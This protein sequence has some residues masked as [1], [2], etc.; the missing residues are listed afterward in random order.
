MSLNFP[1]SPTIGQQ[2]SAAGQT[3]VWNGTVWSAYRGG[4]VVQTGASAPTTVAEGLVWFNTN[5]GRT[6]VYYD[7]TWVDTATSAAI[8]TSVVDNSSGDA[9]TVIQQGAGRALAVEGTVAVTGSLNATTITQA[10]SAVSLASELTSH[11]SDTTNIHGIADTSLLATKA[12]ADSAASAA[13]AGVVDSAPETLNTLN[14]LAAALGDDANFATSVTTAIAAKVS[15]SG[16]SIS[17][18]LTVSGTVDAGTYLQNGAALEM[19]L[20]PYFL[21]GV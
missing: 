17:G 20:N 19:G 2:F 21:I 4:P 5:N 7:G 13:A 1:D 3:W 11:A 8:S 10:G 18:N 14:E 16:D 15:K 9:F 6:Y 12:Y